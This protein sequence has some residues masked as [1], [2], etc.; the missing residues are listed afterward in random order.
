ML[1]LIYPGV[2]SLLFPSL[3]FERGL[4]PLN[5]SLAVRVMENSSQV[6]DS[7]GKG[8]TNVC[9]PVISLYGIRNTYDQHSHS[10]SGDHYI[11]IFFEFCYSKNTP[12]PTNRPLSV[13]IVSGETPEEKERCSH[14]CDRI[15]HNALGTGVNPAKIYLFLSHTLGMIIALHKVG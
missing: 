13:L 1:L 3:F 10:H 8:C 2:E 9:W 7:S 11:G 6:G 14:W 5:E 4:G 15:C 12:R